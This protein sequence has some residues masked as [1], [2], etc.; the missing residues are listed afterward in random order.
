[1]TIEDDLRATFAR[2][3]AAAPAADGLPDKIK[4]AVVRRK[5]RRAITG[6]AAAVLAVGALLPIA[7]NGLHR[8]AVQPMDL[9]VGQAPTP[10]PADGVNVL[11]IGTDRGLG[12]PGVSADTVLIAH[13]AADLHHAYLVKLPRT[14][15]VAGGGTLG[16]TYRAG[17]AARTRS[18][19][20]DLTGLD[21]DATVTFDPATLTAVTDAVGG[22][23]LCLNPSVAT[24]NPTGCQRLDGADVVQMMHGQDVAGAQRYLWALAERVTA[25]ETLTNPAKLD[26]LVAL[27]DRHGLTIEGDLRYLLRAATSIRAAEIVGVSAP[28]SAPLDKIYPQVGPS[29]YDALRRDDL[30][31]W[32]ANHPAYALTR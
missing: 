22:V 19:V 1:M 24:P 16:E 23:D 5:R 15:Q 26:K 27:A 12:G 14:G 2:H 4:T 8:P 18:V 21:F 17:G 31:A 25:T 20:A 7:V 11:V 6:A 29:L 32:I 10:A 13:V 30:A 3:E 28:G 9:L